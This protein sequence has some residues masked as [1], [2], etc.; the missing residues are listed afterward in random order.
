MIRAISKSYKQHICDM[1]NHFGN[2]LAELLKNGKPQVL[3]NLFELLKEVFSSGEAVENCVQMFLPL[4]IRKSSSA[5]GATKTLAQE[6]LTTIS[7]S[8][9]YPSTFNG[10]VTVN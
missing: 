9:G 1:M 6:V 3:K 4:V 2:V 7:V 10:K 8:C 5:V